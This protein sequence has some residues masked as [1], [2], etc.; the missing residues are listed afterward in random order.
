ML[1]INVP[2]WWWSEINWR[3][4][5]QSNFEVHFMI[6]KSQSKQNIRRLTQMLM[7]QNPQK[8]RFSKRL[9][10]SFSS[11]S[12]HSKWNRAKKKSKRNLIKQLFHFDCCFYSRPLRE[13]WRDI[14][15]DWKKIC[16]FKTRGFRKDD[17]ITRARERWAKPQ[18]HIRNRIIG[19]NFFYL[20]IKWYHQH[21]TWKKWSERSLLNYQAKGNFIVNIKPNEESLTSFVYVRSSFS[22]EFTFLRLTKGRYLEVILEVI[23]YI[24]QWTEKYWKIPTLT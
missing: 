15:H 3:M 21:C 17:S 4:S 11:K 13:Y 10:R 22:K 12:P 19:N 14:N 24:K 2:S 23:K 5:K 18:L 7:S 9:R 20:S 8:L 6:H 1:H 16:G